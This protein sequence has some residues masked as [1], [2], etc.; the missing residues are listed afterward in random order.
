ME[1]V[2]RRLRET[3]LLQGIWGD[4]QVATVAHFHRRSSDHRPV[5][6]FRMAYDD[7]G[8]YVDFHVSDRYV[9]CRRTKTQ[10]MVCKDSCVEAFLQP[11]PDKGYFNFEINCGGTMLLYYVTDP[12]RV[13]GVGLK[14]FEVVPAELIQRVKIEHSLPQ[15]VWPEHSTPLEW[16]VTLFAPNE[17]FEH[18]VGPLGEPATRRWRGN[19]YKCADES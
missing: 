12:T 10:S 4:A 6:Q 8:I 14:A 3:P 16:R 1:Y 5:T 19:F 13:P 17:L 15:V 11:K 7:G 18:Y 9:L 2:V